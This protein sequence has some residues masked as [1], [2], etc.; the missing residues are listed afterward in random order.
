MG[1]L[2]PQKRIEGVPVDHKQWSQLE[3]KMASQYGKL[4]IIHEIRNNVLCLHPLFRKKDMYR[5][6]KD[7]F[8]TITGATFGGVIPAISDVVFVSKDKSISLFKSTD[9]IAG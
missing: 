2:A 6:D 3:F 8:F 1:M 5:V 4:Y 9:I 7:K